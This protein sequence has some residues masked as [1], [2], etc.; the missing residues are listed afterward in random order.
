MTEIFYDNDADLSLIQ[1]KKVAVIGYGSQGHA[2]ALNLRDSG[3]EVDIGLKEG[4]KS[5]AE[6]RGGRLR[7]ADR[8]G[9]RQ[10][11]RRHRHPRARPAPA[12]HLRRR[13][14]GQPRGRQRDPRSGTASTSASATSRR[15]RASTSSWSPRRAPAT[16]CVAST[17]PGRG[18][19]VIVAVEQDATGS[20]WDARLELREGASA[21]CVPAASRPPSPRRPRPTCSASRP[22]SAAAPRSSSSTASRPSSRRATSRRSP[23]S[24]CCTS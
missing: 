7:G 24:R 11:G 16:R 9:C 5:I 4:S 15:P 20:A 1:G 12:R 3:V 19:P 18:V 22:C 21:A 8:R 10:V 17:R 23:T 6:G 2:H 14:Q 13:H